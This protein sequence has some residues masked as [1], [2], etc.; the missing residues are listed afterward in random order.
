MRLQ[1]LHKKKIVPALMEQYHYKNTLQAPRLVKVV[2]N[3]GFGRQ[4]KEKQFVDN[5]VKGLTRITG[6]KPILSKAKKSISSFKIRQGMIIGASTTLRGKRMYDFVEKLV[7]ISFPR[8]RDFRGI[9]SKS[10][11]RNGNLTVGLHEHLAFPE[12]KADEVENIFGLEI[13]LAT[14]AESKKEGLSLFEL[15][16]FPFIKT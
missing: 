3:V 6:Q 8:V 2:V 13:S 16:G 4:A 9:S 1:E 5:V 14:T 15:M 12:I 7:N 11:D 10:V